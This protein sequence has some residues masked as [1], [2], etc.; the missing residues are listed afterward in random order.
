[1]KKF[2]LTLLVAG[3]LSALSA[4]SNT[5][6]NNL[7][8]PQS[9]LTSETASATTQQLNSLVE[10]Y[11]VDSLQFSPLDATYIGYNQYNNQFTAPITEQ[12]RAQQ[13]AFYKDY[14][15]RLAAIDQQQ[16]TGQALLSYEILA[17]DLA[18][19]IEGF[20]FP[21]YLLPI[22]QMSGAHNT[23][24][25]FGSAQ[26]AQPF[27]SYQDYENFVA[28]AEG[29]VTWLSSVQDAMQQGVNE[30]I[31]LPKPLAEKLLPQFQAHIV[32]S[33]EQS[34]FYSPIKQL[35]EQ[36]TAA[37]KQQLTDQYSALIMDKLVPAY[38]KMS[39]FLA[40][41]YIPN[42]RATVGY[43]DL[44][45]GKAWYEYQIKKN[46]TLSLSADEIHEI[47]LKEV[48]RILNEMK[49]VKETVGFKGSLSEFFT[50]LR[51]S[52]EFYFDTPEQLIAAYEAV[53][54]KIDA[55][56]PKLFNIVP[57]A[58]YVVKAVEDFRA[59]SA[60][61]ASYQSPAPDGSRPGIFYINT[62]N[63][64]AQPKFLL[65]TLSIHEAAPGHHFQ[66]ALQQEVQ[67]LP[68][69][70]KFG[71]YTVFAEGWALYAE[72]LGK[73][74]GLFTD[75]YMW[76]GRLSDEQLRAM[77]LV[78]DT[79]FHAKG[80][81][82]QQGIDYMLANSSMA[83]SDVTAEVERYIAWPGQALSYKL[84]QF[85]IQEL[86]D[87]CKQALGDKFDIKE[88]HTQILIDG[89]LPM[90]ILEAKIKRWVDTQR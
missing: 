20:Q 35:P 6:N 50:H 32:T 31:V 42:S 89:A 76:Y 25:G 80:W 26:S 57:K 59:E 47:G 68:E 64:K 78:L 45:N 43:S 61:G 21:S 81:T 10:Q 88:F 49:K 3:V 84:G 18:L 53:K 13:L 90:P 38:T 77:R 71:G 27:A 14:Q 7:N 63:L 9:A 74:L 85:K 40:T 70:R 4:C 82:R 23:F 60:A 48:S 54:L 79:G 65:E 15:Q 62:F 28:R 12:N 19:T 51:D 16:L 83:L 69:F 30:G 52:D 37:Q 67:S 72:S 11:F 5:A 39:E 34:L 36:F 2:K 55:R 41:T 17:R 29:F 56:V 44:P 33:A 24:A 58:D 86:R 66:I 73:E 22:N 46:T 75:P 87:Y 8:K 1:M